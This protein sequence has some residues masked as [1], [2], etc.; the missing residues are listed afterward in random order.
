MFKKENGNNYR[1]NYGKEVLPGKSHRVVRESDTSLLNRHGKDIID[2]QGIF[3]SKLSF[4]DII[5]RYREEGGI[6]KITVRDDFGV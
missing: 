3:D 5:N 6:I 1:I 4:T 2:A